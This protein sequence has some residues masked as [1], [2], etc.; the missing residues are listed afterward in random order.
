[1]DAEPRPA[2]RLLRAWR[3]AEDRVRQVGSER[4]AISAGLPGQEDSDAACTERGQLVR[5]AIA[6]LEVPDAHD[7]DHQR[8][9]MRTR[10][11]HERLGDGAVPGELRLHEVP[12]ASLVTRLP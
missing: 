11:G 6:V 3:N 4:R 12:A 7:A 8:P 9:G 10:G 5:H 2:V 1:R